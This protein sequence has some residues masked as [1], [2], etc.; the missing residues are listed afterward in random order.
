[1][2]V[3]CQFRPFTSFARAGTIQILFL[4]KL[5]TCCP[6]RFYTKQIRRQRHPKSGNSLYFEHSKHIY[7]FNSNTF[8]LLKQIHGSIELYN[9]QFTTPPATMSMSTTY[10]SN[11][12]W[13]VLSTFE[14]SYMFT[15]S[16]LHSV[17]VCLPMHFFSVEIIYP[18]KQRT[19]KLFARK[20]LSRTSYRF[21][22]HSQRLT[23]WFC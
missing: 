12:S 1:M 14:I 7:T 23:N 13:L 6:N 5:V 20:R 3:I 10:Q 18:W 22:D 4:Q 8:L 16:T 19:T 9:T 11:S 15:S 2:D 17:R 21:L